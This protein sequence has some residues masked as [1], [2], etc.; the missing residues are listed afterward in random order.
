M[1][2]NTRRIFC[3][4]RRRSR[5]A[6]RAQGRRWIEPRARNERG[7]VR[8]AVKPVAAA[9]FVAAFSA[10]YAD[11]GASRMDVP[12]VRA[13]GRNVSY[14]ELSPRPLDTILYFLRQAS[15]DHPVS[16]ARTRLKEIIDLL[17]RDKAE[18]RIVEAIPL[19]H[20]HPFARVV[21]D[22]GGKPAIEYSLVSWT[23]SVQGLAS[24]D[25][26]EGLKDLTVAATLH[27]WEHY[28]LHH[29]LGADV[30]KKTLVSQESEVWQSMIVEVLAPGRKEQHFLLSEKDDSQTYY[31]LL[32]F[33]AADGK[34]DHPA[35][36]AFLSW[37]TSPE[38]TRRVSSCR[39]MEKGRSAR[40]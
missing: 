24:A 2:L 16:T 28:R 39:N 4:R 13:H 35:W 7:T 31:G 5:V 14:T 38:P 26:T 29:R 30:E 36:K 27:G 18:A 1:R 10:A 32:C 11:D 8:H 22:A 21:M 17:D 3:A 33:G 6:R 15:F 20:Q 9:L 40:L 37:V 23:Q 25:L 12:M 19:D 34:L